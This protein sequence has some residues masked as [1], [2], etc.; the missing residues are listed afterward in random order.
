MVAQ[1]PTF[2]LGAKLKKTVF[3]NGVVAWG[4]SSRKYVQSA[5]HNVQEYLVALPGD[6]KLLKKASGPF[7]L[8]YKP[9]IDDSPELDPIR[10]IF[11]QSHIEIL[12]WCV[13]LVR[14]DIITE[15]S[16]LSNHLCV[17]HEGHIE[18]VFHVFSYMGLHHN[19]RVA[20]DPT[21]PCVDMGAFIKTVCKSMYG[22]VKKMVPSDAHVPRRKE[23][24]LRLFFNF[25]HSYKKFTSRSRT[26][27]DIYL[28]MAPIVWFS[29]RH[30]TVGSSVFGDEYVVMKSGIEAWCG[31]RYKLIM[32]GLALS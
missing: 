17:P 8:G 3:P 12:R 1:V 16:M 23:V 20:V 2:Y 11:Y 22:Y 15:V 21:Y 4:M 13:E 24:D 31:L 10:A 27:C 26:G 32:M 18:A 7:A 29:K 30:P 25:D 9:E 5:V 14:I 19:A 6:Q 28:N